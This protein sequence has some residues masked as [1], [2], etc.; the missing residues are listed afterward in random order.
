MCGIFVSSAMINEFNC[1]TRSS[2]A[3]A[4]RIK[5]FYL[6]VFQKCCRI[7]SL[8]MLIYGRKQIPN[9]QT[10]QSK[11]S[12]RAASYYD[13]TI[14][15]SFRDVCFQITINIKIC[16]QMFHMHQHMNILTWDCGMRCQRIAVL[17]EGFLY[18]DGTFAILL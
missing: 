10:G 8:L 16:G 4:A 14:F 2:L 17:E 11:C 1:L 18:E 5:Q 9:N 7:H 3:C 13:N 12:N 6:S 15:D